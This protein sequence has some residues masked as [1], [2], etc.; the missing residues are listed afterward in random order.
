MSAT[1]YFLSLCFVGQCLAAFA[2]GY[3]DR[4]EG[5]DSND[6][7]FRPTCPGQ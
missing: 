5:V 4:A 1:L 6:I 2:R 3:P 7:L